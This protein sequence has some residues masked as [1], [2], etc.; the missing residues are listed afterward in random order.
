MLIQRNVP[1][2]RGHKANKQGWYG[3]ETLDLEAV[4]SMAP[5]ATLLYEGAKDNQN[6]NLLE[7]VTDVVDNHLA[8]IITNSY[9]S[10]GENVGDVSA[11]EAVYTQAITE[12]IGVYF[13]SGDCGDN[14]DPDGACGGV[15]KRR[16]DY[17][18]S[19]PN[20]IS[21]GG[22][23]LG[24]GASNDYLFETG[25]GTGFSGLAGGDHWDPAPPGL[26]F[27]G[28]GG[29]TSRVFD[30]PTTRRASCPS[31]CRGTGVTGPRTVWSRTSPPWVTRTLGS[32]SVRPRRS[33]MAR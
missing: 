1:P 11:E 28:G 30:E 21:V 25:W 17:P 4:H 3:E 12:G 19:S 24:V 2:E 18:A 22:T 26:Y 13:S 6:V 29:G 10:R 16:T 20:V 31:R 7:R 33:P 5:G 9:G 27:Y 8:S 14:I 32:R 23:S 15:G